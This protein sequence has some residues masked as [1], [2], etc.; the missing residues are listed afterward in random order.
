MGQGIIPSPR[1]W[2]QVDQI[3]FHVDD[4]SRVDYH[5]LYPISNEL[6]L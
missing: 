4:I 2:V 3:S 6:T 1:S 5:Q